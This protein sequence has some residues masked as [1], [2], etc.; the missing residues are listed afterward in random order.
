[1]EK[2]VRNLSVVYYS[3][4]G[5]SRKIARAIATGTGLP[6]VQEIDLT[7]DPEHA[8][9][10]VEGDALI[11]VSPV[12]AGRVPL[13]AIGRMKRLCGR[14]S[15]GNPIP[16]LLAVVYGNRD[17]D[18]ALLELKDLAVEWGFLPVAAGAFIGEHSY[19]RENMPVAANRPDSHDLEMAGSFG[20][21]AVE[22]YLSAAISPSS[23]SLCVKGNYPYKERKP[24]NSDAPYCTDQCNSCGLCISLCPVQ[25]ISFDADHHIQ[26]DALACTLCCACVKMCPNQARVYDTPFTRFLYE[27][28]SQRKEP[29]F[30][31]ASSGSASIR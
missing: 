23:F 15:D 7:L 6:V 14:K 28:F 26:T 24:A 2:S 12:Y 29:E 19:S 31:Y 16:A 17:Y 20:A 1:M 18:D 11:L 22:T 25:A 21:K 3:P 4:T 9:L 8:P 13:T 27:N 10:T 30:F 5:T